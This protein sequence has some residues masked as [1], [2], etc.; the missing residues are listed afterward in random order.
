MLGAVG[1]TDCILF[2]ID[3]KVPWDR[4]PRLGYLMY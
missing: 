4:S 1:V 3:P 2:M